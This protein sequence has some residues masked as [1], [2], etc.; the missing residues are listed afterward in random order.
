MMPAMPLMPY[1]QAKPVPVETTK[2]FGCSMKWKSKVDWRR[3]LDERWAEKAVELSGIDLAGARELVANQGENLRLINVWAT[4][5]GPCII[6]FPEFIDIQ[7]IYGQRGFE[8]VSVSMD[9]PE[10]EEK[11]LDF[12]RENQAAFDN[13]LNTSTDRD[14][15]INAFDPDWQGNLPFTMLISPGG[16]VIYTHDGIIDPLELKKAIVGQLGRYFADD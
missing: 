16:D 14:V 7:R 12:L 1:W 15:F 11:V 8:V 13:Y 6:E 3:T 2:A 4:W 5:C 10:K 9:R